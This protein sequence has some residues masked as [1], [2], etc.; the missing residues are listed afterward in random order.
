MTPSVAVQRTPA[1]LAAT[2]TTRADAAVQRTPY[3]AFPGLFFHAPAPQSP[4]PT[5]L[6]ALSHPS[7]TR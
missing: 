7:R 5:P 2:R 6:T 3:S 4:V 1:E